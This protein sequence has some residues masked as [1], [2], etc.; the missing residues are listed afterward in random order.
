[1]ARKPASPSDLRPTT[2]RSTDGS[3]GAVGREVKVTKR[4]AQVIEATHRQRRQAMKELA[5]R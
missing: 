3:V 2:S 5:N 4:S 1:M